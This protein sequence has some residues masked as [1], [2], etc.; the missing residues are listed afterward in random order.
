MLILKRWANVYFRASS[1]QKV[2]NI[3][4]CKSGKLVVS[5]ASG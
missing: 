5:S 3:D 2:E 4:I 1:P